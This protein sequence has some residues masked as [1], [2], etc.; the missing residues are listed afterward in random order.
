M[1]WEVPWGFSVSS[2]CPVWKSKPQNRTDRICR[3]DIVAN[4]HNNGRLLSTHACPREGSYYVDRK[5]SFVPQLGH[6]KCADIIDSILRLIFFD[7]RSSSLVVYDDDTV[8]MYCTCILGNEEGLRVSEMRPAKNSFLQ[9][10]S[11]FHFEMW[12]RNEPMVFYPSFLFLLTCS[13]FD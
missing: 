2:D 7:S 13:I 1:D 9:H 11:F 6:P 12:S 4:G 5:S 10:F 3:N 8:P